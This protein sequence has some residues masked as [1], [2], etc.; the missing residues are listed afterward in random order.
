MS[1]GSQLLEGVKGTLLGLP[2]ISVISDA[3]LYTKKKIA[4]KEK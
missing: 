2:D 4:K 3:V 1:C